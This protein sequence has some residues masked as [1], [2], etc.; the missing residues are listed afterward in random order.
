MKFAIIA[1]GEGSR[2]L[3]EGVNIT[4]PLVKISGIPMIERII[5]SAVKNSFSSVHCI[6]NEQSPD[7]KEYLTSKDFGIPLHLLVKSTPSSMHSLFELSDQLKDSGFCLSAA[8]T[9]FDPEEFRNYINYCKD[10]KTEA[11]GVIAVTDFIDDEK[12]LYVKLLHNNDI[13]EFNDNYVE[14]KYVTGGLYFFSPGVFD[15][16]NKALLSGISR[17]RNFL[18]LLL[19]EGYTLKAYKFNKIIDV[20]HLKDIIEA[21]EF[22]SKI[23][24][25]GNITT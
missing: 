2:L 15:I 9:I 19:T 1:A 3:N 4:K 5:D 12:P 7:L 10:N 17:L 18:K 13:H 14:I 6:I 21:E 24:L 16:F 23:T 25:K 20:D 22:L 11:D 8:D